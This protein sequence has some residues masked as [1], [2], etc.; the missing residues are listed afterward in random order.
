M[1][2]I[3]LFH[4]MCLSLVNTQNKCISCSTYFSFMFVFHRFGNKMNVLK[5]SGG[6]EVHSNGIANGQEEEDS[7]DQEKQERE[8]FQ[9]VINA[10]KYYK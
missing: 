5:H 1:F 10:F 9:R 2:F 8:H 7:M 4:C 6:E 3:I